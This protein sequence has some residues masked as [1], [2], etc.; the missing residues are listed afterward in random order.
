MLGA[1]MPETSESSSHHNNSQTKK[2]YLATID[3]ARA[4]AAEL[5]PELTLAFD[6]LSHKTALV[7]RAYITAVYQEGHS[8][9]EIENIR[10][11]MRQYFEDKFGCLG[12]R[13]Q[14]LPDE[15]RILIDG[16]EIKVENQGEWIG[17]P[18]F[19][20]A[21]VDTMRELKTQ[22]D[23]VGVT[24][25]LIRRTAFSYEDM[26]KLMLYLE[27]PETIKTEGEGLCLFFQAFAA[28][29]FT[30]WLK[31]DEVLQLKRGHMHL[32]RV[33]SNKSPWLDLTL[34]CRNSNPFDCAQANVYEIY[35]QPDEPHIC[36]VTKLLAWLQWM[37]RD[38]D[39][40]PQDE[41]FLFPQLT[42]DG[43]IQ[44]D[45][46]FSATQFSNLLNKYARNAGLMD[47]R[48][49]LL[50][51]HCFRR[52]GA[53]HRL[54][55]AQ[56]LWPFKAIKWWGGW[57]ERESAE[58]IIEYLLDEF[59]YETK[60]G[61]MLAPQG[62]K[63]RGHSGTARHPAEVMVMK[64]H[65]ERTIKS[66]ESRQTVD[67][68]RL[69][70]EN[71]E[72]R[73]EC[74]DLL[75]TIELQSKVRHHEL[76]Q[77]NKELRHEIAQL[78]R[79]ITMQLEEA[80]RTLASRAPSATVQLCPQQESIQIQPQTPQLL[81]P[82]HLPP[83]YL[84][85]QESHEQQPSHQ[86]LQQQRNTPS[87]VPSTPSPQPMDQSQAEHPPR[88][89]PVQHQQRP[90]TPPDPPHQLY[91][92]EV[93]LQLSP[94]LIELH[95]AQTVPSVSHWKDAIRQ[96]EKGDPEN[97]LTTPLHRWT[98]G[99]QGNNAAVINSR[100]FIVK[101][102]EFFGRDEIA[103]RAFH[104]DSMD[105]LSRLV[106]SIHD[107][108]NRL[109]RQSSEKRAA[110]SNEMHD[111]D[112]QQHQQSQQSTKVQS[113]DKGKRRM[114]EDQHLPQSR[115]VG[116]TK[117][118]T[119]TVKMPTIPGVS[120]WKDTVL[121]WPFQQ[122]IKV[123]S[124]SKGK[125]RT[126]EDQQPPQS[127]QTGATKAVK[128]PGI[129]RVS[130]WKDVILQWDKGDPSRGLVVPLCKWTPAMI[131]QHQST[132]TKRKMVTKEFERLGHSE[133][134]MQEMYGND[135]EGGLNR[136]CN[137]MR[138]KRWLSIPGMGQEIEEEEQG[139][140]P[141]RFDDVQ[142]HRQQESTRN[143]SQQQEVMAP[144]QHNSKEDSQAQTIPRASSWQEAVRQWD[145]GDPKNGL[146]MPLCSW[147]PVM[148]RSFSPMF[149]ER[150]LI[151]N[152]FDFHGRSEDK[153]KETYGD[154]L[155][156]VNRLVM[157]IVQKR[158]Q[159]KV[160][161]VVDQ[162]NAQAVGI[163]LDEQGQEVDKKG[164]EDYEEVDPQM[165]AVPK[166]IHWKEAVQQWEEGD[167]ARGLYVPFRDWPDAWLSKSQHYQ[168]YKN[169]KMIAEEFEFCKRDSERM[170]Q[171]YGTNMDSVQSL[172]QSIH[173]RR[174]LSSENVRQSCEEREDEEPLLRKR[175]VAMEEVD[176][177]LSVSKKTR[178]EL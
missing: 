29:A 98:V 95:Q 28:I 25:R 136:L 122:N 154:N 158:R 132:Y 87:L 24:R 30:I 58:K 114:T 41:D 126:T 156:T 177:A 175:R 153:M 127:R 9:N 48:Y 93:P 37:A 81:P 11:A 109:I 89:Q 137:V 38:M 130:H 164:G 27:K 53:Q 26:T 40:P 71:Q 123:E 113:V 145:N 10:D 69:E 16:V 76:K 72:T 5:G 52:G 60:F 147:T 120:N 152:E 141:T 100:Q 42:S 148:I 146:T 22:D 169:R 68:S 86:Q 85:P 118:A 106:Q 23:K 13:W 117:R 47:H 73:R 31:F 104:G 32:G 101:E 116:A 140:R 82:Q 161:K 134:R 4:F 78:R 173:R 172:L 135:L 105:D 115:Q 39:R 65:L 18:V 67:F 160:M 75:Q 50:D 3:Q 91:P 51:T 83:Q 15:D 55:Y 36:F 110:D 171:Q 119:N 64:A 159:R 1:T 19:D 97:G 124:V 79:T 12:D 131:A 133:S 54:M 90:A 45:K 121:Q 165:P 35:S 88:Q 43:G 108:N 96:W 128:L 80:V 94:H 99:M 14:F 162:I 155:D 6:H 84:P 174:H 46:P 144:E 168:M 17:N 20:T 102:F 2:P 33:N 151:A 178:P 157:A 125:G 143:N 44:H 21:F 112:E 142:D 170:R 49:N 62:S 167:L 56:D 63:T 8:Y 74:R 66:M 77:E 138:I 163:V 7:L 111:D 34:P 176:D 103:M 59:Q 70:S 61:D 57:S 129:P 139:Q 92:T 166:I 149:H 150:A 107:R